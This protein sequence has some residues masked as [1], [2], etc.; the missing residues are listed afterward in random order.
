MQ[1][2]ISFDYICQVS[3]DDLRA[4]A[5]DEEYDDR[6]ELGGGAAGRGEAPLS[7]QLPGPQ[8]ARRDQHDK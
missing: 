1:L 2:S 4:A 3:R 7:N 5:D 6:E 8:R